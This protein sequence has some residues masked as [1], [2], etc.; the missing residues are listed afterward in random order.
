MPFSSFYLAGNLE[1]KGT[2]CLQ[3]CV[4]NLTE[5][6]CNPCHRECQSCFGATNTE[7]LAC[8]PNKTVH[9]YRCVDRCPRGFYKQPG[10]P[11]MPCHRE[12]AACT[13][14]LRTQCTSCPVGLKFFNGQCVAKCPRGYFDHEQWC[15]KCSHNCAECQVS[16]EICMYCNADKVWRDLGC[17]DSCGPGRFDV[18]GTRR[19]GRCHHTCKTCFG[20]NANQCLSCPHGMILYKSMCFEDCPARYIPEASTTICNKCPENCMR[21]SGN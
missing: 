4:D 11:C 5:N 6:S 16:M 3:P 20:F 18:K 7:C 15:L 21:C 10:R 19:C 12:C 8:Y 2:T 14:E 17:H 13:G 9:D 1:L